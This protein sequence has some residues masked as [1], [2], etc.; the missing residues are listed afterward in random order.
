VSLAR[1]FNTT[2]S[3]TL[4]LHTFNASVL[5]YTYIC[6]AIV[7]PLIGYLNT[8]LEKRIPFAQ[9]HLYNIVGYFMILGSLRLAMSLTNAGWPVFIYF[10]WSE[11]GWILLNL[12]LWGLAGRLLTVRQAKRL[13]GLIGASGSLVTISVG[14]FL[15][16]IVRKVG[17]SNLLLIVM[18]AL[19]GA[20]GLLIFVNRIYSG[21]LADSAT[22]QDSPASISSGWQTPRRYLNM[23]IILAMVTEASFYFVDIIFYKQVQIEYASHDKFVNYPV[24]ELRLEEQVI[25]IPKASDVEVASFMGKYLAGMNLLVLLS[26][27]FLVAPLINRL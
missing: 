21:Q 27:F 13:F 1:L 24:G 3:S 4:F 22:E 6:M 7:A 8:R 9:L 16:G 18:S 26:N 15:S 25:S 19:A 11:I 20:I 17:V 2:A 5:P 23:L 14:F 10:M 12:M